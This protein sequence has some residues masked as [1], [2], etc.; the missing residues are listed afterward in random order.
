MTAMKARRI[1]S[2]L[3]SLLWLLPAS[4][5]ADGVVMGTV[6]L[7]GVAIPAEYYLSGNGARLGS[8]NNAC[9]PQYSVGK[10][11]VPATIT[12]NN[13]DYPVCEVSPLAFRL[14]TM[15]TEVV[16]PENVYHIGDFAFKGCLAL[17]KV[18]L[19]STLGSIGTGAFI[20]LP[21]L[22]TIDCKAAIPPYWVY[23]DV[24]KFH[25]GGIGDAATYSYDILLM[26]PEGTVSTYH[27]KLYTDPSLG[28]TTP[29]GWGNFTNITVGAA[30]NAEAYVAYYPYD[31][32]LTFYFDGHRADRVG[33]ETY[34]IDETYAGVPKWQHDH[35]DDITSVVFSPLFSYARPT[36]T[37]KWF[38]DFSALNSIQG[39][40]HLAT[41]EVTDMSYM[42]RN[43]TALTDADIDLSHF[44]T[45]KVTTMLSMFE[46]C[47]GIVQPDFSH[48]DTRLCTKMDNMFYGC[49][50]LESI[51]LSSFETTACSFDDMFKNCT[52]L[53]SVDIGSLGVAEDDIC[54]DMFHNCSSLTTIVIP[55]AFNKM[56]YAFKGCDQLRTI[57]CYKPV[58]FSYWLG[59]EQDFAPNKSAAFHVLASTLDAWL[60]AY[61]P[62]AT[63]P[64][65]VTF[66]GDLGTETNP[67]LLYGTPDWI[68]LGL[69]V[70]N[71]LTIHAKMMNDITVST[72]TGN[73]DHL[74]VGTFDGNGHTL[75]VTMPDDNGTSLKAPFYCTGNATIKNLV[76]DGTIQGGIHSSGLVG[77]AANGA[78]LTIENCCVKASVSARSNNTSG[79]HIGGFVGHGHNATIAINGCLFDGTLETLENNNDSYAG[80]FIGWCASTDNKTVTNCYENGTYIQYQHVG[81]N[82]DQQASATAITMTNCYHNHSWGEAPHAYSFTTDTEGL[83]LDFGTPTATYDVSGITAYNPGVKLNGTF[84]AGPSQTFHIVMTAPGYEY[85]LGNLSLSGNA[86]LITTNNEDYDITLASADAVI[87]I[88]NMV[89][90]TIVLYDDATDNSLTLYQHLDQTYKV[91]LKGHTIPKAARWTPLCLPFDLTN[92]NNTPLQGAMLRVLDTITFE[93]K[94]A[95]FHF[96]D[97]TAITANKPYLVRVT[98]SSDIV[99]PI[100]NNV[101][102]KRS[103][104]PGMKVELG[105]FSR[106]GFGVMGNYNRINL[107][108]VEAEELY[109]AFYFDGT[110]LRKVHTTT[111]LNA[112][113]CFFE[114]LEVNLDEVVACVLK[115]DNGNSYF[116]MLDENVTDIDNIFFSDGDWDEYTNWA[117]DIVPT[118]NDKVLIEGQATI[119]SDCLAQAKEIV[120]DQG[121]ITIADGGQLLYD[122]PGATVTMQKNIEAYDPDH[123]GLGNTDG[124]YFIAT[125]FSGTYTPVDTILLSNTYDLYRLNNTV[126]E[127]FKNTEGHPDFTTLN[128]G[129]GYLYANSGN[130]TLQ[131]VGELKPY[132]EEGANNQVSVSAGWN[133]IGNPF[134]CNVYA[135]RTYF[136][137]NA[138]HTGIEA[139]DNYGANPIAPC[140]GIV[141]EAEA[142]GNVTFSKDAPMQ[143]QSNNGSL[144]ITLTQAV[145]STDPDGRFASLR[146]GTTKQSSTIDNAIISFNTGSQLGK[147]YFGTQNANIYIPQNGEDYAIA[148]SDKQGEMPLNFKATKDGTYT[149]SVNPEGVEMGYLHLIDNMTGNDVDLLSIE[150]CGSES[151][152]TAGRSAMTTG[153]VSYTFNAKTTDYESRFKLV[154]VANN[155]PST[156]SGTDEPF[157]FYSNGD[158]IIA[159]PS[160]GSGVATLQ[161]IDLTGRILSSET[162]SGSVRKAINAVPGVY[163]LRLINGN[164]VKT[165]KIVVK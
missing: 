8:G 5:W 132:S 159:N 76:V 103:L 31:H 63:I 117:K 16:L 52:N 34:G 112:F 109:A 44:N 80:A 18:T 147:F 55:S 2:L 64:A 6:T 124:W 136:R 162:V 133:L 134:A 115:I 82:Y 51:D 21:N 14:C 4:A 119:P 116:S 19:P 138:T 126:W 91:Q 50:A 86:T 62:N 97:T 13:V 137:M 58:P 163:V 144:N 57:Y 41:D 20:D 127:N 32:S 87:N 102:I 71:S 83:V 100:F 85:S 125:P 79:P 65:N 67:I 152:M 25:S 78:T 15:I 104:P 73:I 69:M 131:L 46:G 101:T 158:W 72:M 3:I 142:D 89:F 54:D 12:V 135:N 95:I 59:C 47:T 26:V 38:C 60:E 35:K 61:G 155:G 145:E 84:H 164:D 94:V 81:M 165:Q 43:C 122:K 157:A 48:F 92:L 10:V 160:T 17:T 113:R 39:M 111:S 149:L 93:N 154:F 151:A 23:N 153:G 7:D 123:T 45:S 146:E 11:E 143:A 130:V 42:F 105:E 150:D 118:S 161:V 70:E 141:V 140:T 156:G 28:W 106:N 30:A 75:H 40:E 74:F 9:I 77:Q 148:F 27:T 129:R 36:S 66:V 22:N 120:F 33:K 29:D 90:T 1:Y 56:K 128:N 24:F 139:V 68:N 37:S 88:A 96:K 53:T 98:G 49:T 121:T 99:D 114:V 108:D 107:R 110:S